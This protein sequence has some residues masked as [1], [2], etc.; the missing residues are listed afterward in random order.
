MFPCH[1][2]QQDI[3]FERLQKYRRR[4]VA[5]H[6]DI[7]DNSIDAMGKNLMSASD[8]FSNSSMFTGDLADL[9]GSSDVQDEALENAEGVPE[10][11]AEE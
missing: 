3:S 10:A 8:G 2:I 5:N 11:E 6:D 7:T 4:M 1:C 9:M